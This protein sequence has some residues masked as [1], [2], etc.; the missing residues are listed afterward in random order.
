MD[1][2]K[3]RCVRYKYEGSLGLRDSRILIILCTYIRYPTLNIQIRIWDTEYSNSDMDGSER[4]IESRL[5]YGQ[6]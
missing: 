2:H 3:V 4:D 5:R 1:K 6:I